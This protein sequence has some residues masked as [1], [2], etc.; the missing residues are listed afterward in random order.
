VISAC[1]ELGEGGGTRRSLE[2]E[3]L[4]G[5]PS[6][7]F[8]LVQNKNHTKIWPSKIMTRN[9]HKPMASRH[10]NLSRTLFVILGAIFGMAQR[11]HAYEPTTI[12]PVQ[13]STAEMK[14]LLQT[15]TY[16]WAGSSESLRVFRNDNFASVSAS[17]LPRPVPP[18][19]SLPLFLAHFFQIFYTIIAVSQLE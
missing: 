10:Y 7:C 8:R 3:I 18:I 15:D 11:A 9:I 1:N 13:A 16:T 19:F 14:L 2:S 5:P 6:H 17:L 4:R 12:I